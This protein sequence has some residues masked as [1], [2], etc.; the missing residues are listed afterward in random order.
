MKCLICSHSEGL[1]R[2]A[3]TCA[4]CRAPYHADCWSYQGRCARFGCAEAVPGEPGHVGL[5]ERGPR[6]PATVEADARFT[7]DSRFTADAKL[8]ADIDVAAHRARARDVARARL[9]ERMISAYLAVLIPVAVLAY[10][11]RPPPYTP[12]SQ[13][14]GYLLFGLG[15]MPVW[16]PGVFVGVPLAGSYL[17]RRIAWEFSGWRLV[18]VAAVST[19]LGLALRLGMDTASFGFIP[20]QLVFAILAAN[21]TVR[22]I[23]DPQ[24][25]LITLILQPLGAIVV[26]V[27][28]EKLAILRGSEFFPTPEREWLPI[29]ACASLL[30]S[31]ID[32]FLGHRLHPDTLSRDAATR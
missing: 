11:C 5:F 27:L 10:M 15:T 28:I 16:L 3:V 1:E 32:F 18:A 20:P 25:R 2:A 26:F 23:E 8:T 19:A 14:F 4:R 24:D 17:T 31:T 9:V 22:L 30:S 7:A 13:C 21:A 12:D 29:V 6:D